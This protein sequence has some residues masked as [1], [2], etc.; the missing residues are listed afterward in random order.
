MSSAAVTRSGTPSRYNDILVA[1]AIATIIGM[2]VTPLPP[3]LLDI[4]LVLNTAISLVVLLISMYVTE[5]LQFSVF[6]SLLLIITLFRLGL[7]V[8]TSRLILSTGDAG[9]VIATF[10]SFVVGGNYV[11]GVVIFV[12]LLV[13]Q[14]LV[15]TNGA[16][17]VAEVAARFTLDAM[18]GKQLSIDADLNSGL[19][20]ED[21]ARRRR[22][23]VAQ[24][25][26]FY[27]AMDGASKFVKGDAIAA[28]VIVVVNI[29]G[30][31]VIGIW[32]LKMDILQALQTYTLLTVGQGL[33][34]QIPSILVSAATG[35]LVTRS[36]A[37]GALGS[38]MTQ[39]F[40]NPKALLMVAGFLLA[41]GLLPSVPKLPFLGLGAIIGAVGWV[42]RQ[43]DQTA[44]AEGQLAQLPPS[45]APKALAAP[46]ATKA[47]L[48]V[49]P[50][51][52]EI[53]YGLIPLV[54]ETR[55]DNLLGRV[56]SIRRQLATDLGFIL[57]KV[58]IRDNLRLAPNHYRIKLRGAVVAQGELMLRHLLAMP[59]RPDAPPL[60]GI[61]TTE[62]AFGLPAWWIKEEEKTDAEL[63]G[64]T[65]IDPLSV[66]VTHI[67]ETIKAH[68]PHL[69]GVQD[70]QNLLDNLREST[71][72]A[73]DGVIPDRLGLS[74]LQEILRNLLRERISIRDLT[75]IL[76]TV[77]RYSTE[78]QD[79]AVL[80][81][82]ARRALSYTISDQ[83]A[84]EGVIHVA[85]MNPATEDLLAKSLR[86][87]QQLSLEPQTTQTLLTRIGDAMETLAKLQHS[88]VL[89]CHAEVRFALSRLTRRALP[90][91]AVLS[92]N[93]I[94]P[95]IDVEAHAMV[96]LEAA[97]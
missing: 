41:L 76:E 32:Q 39:Q 29:V 28:V 45:G 77:G 12:T 40:R 82:L 7:N 88:P 65:I 37:Q 17:R 86:A 80:S 1:L 9:K 10:G 62:P 8:S 81:E 11:V 18:P 55:E 3:L 15:I 50:L 66:L 68:A 21:E 64:Y 89:L 53:G 96:S 5:A 72:A 69:L 83:Y 75:A 33:V 79:P 31:F 70:V 42:L 30:G 91:L 19:I 60:K 25:A 43:K 92:Y 71:P 38:E 57:P 6:P 93:E 94:S 84:S 54:D 13:I 59:S 24:E 78:T 61:Q 58:R 63:V 56:T 95:H 16:G 27:G 2:M 46:E 74:E 47:L 23:V 36:A 26:D 44:E 51:E 49:D 87:Q 97:T 14:F 4:L 73:V 48:Q 85:T 35:L 90:N 22:Q 67:S 20:D 52:L 34:T